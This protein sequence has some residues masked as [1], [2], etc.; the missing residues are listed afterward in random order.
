MNVLRSGI[1]CLKMV[2][3]WI[4]I[5]VINPGLEWETTEIRKERIAYYELLIILTVNYVKNR[6][7][8]GNF[9][10]YVQKFFPRRGIAPPKPCSMD[11]RRHSAHKRQLQHRFSR[12]NTLEFGLDRI[13]ICRPSYKIRL[14]G[15]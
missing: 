8:L 4:D 1:F 2:Y 14:V 6:I 12:E 5:P 10:V 3:V 15:G 9:F 11:P 7:K 13:G